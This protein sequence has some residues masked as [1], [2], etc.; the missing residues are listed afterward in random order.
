MLQETYVLDSEYIDGKELLYFPRSHS[1][2]NFQLLT[3]FDGQFLEQKFWT[4]VI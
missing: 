4:L 2:Q 3:Q 1:C